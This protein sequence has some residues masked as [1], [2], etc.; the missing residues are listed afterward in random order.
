MKVKLHNK[1]EIFQGDTKITSYNTMLKSVYQAIADLKDFSSYIALGT[2][3]G[4]S[5]FDNENLEEY[6]SSYALTLEEKSCNIDSNEMFVKK[7]ITFGENEYSGLKFS[8]IGI[9]DTDDENPT[10]YNRILIKDEDG[11]VLSVE[12]REG[13]ALTIRITIYLSV[14]ND[15]KRFFT[16]G[17][18]PLL[19]QMMGESG[20]LDKSVY[21][22][23]GMYDDDNSKSIERVV[24][25]GSPVKCEIKT[26][27]S[28][29][30][31]F[32]F[33]IIAS[34]GT[35]ETL[36]VVFLYGGK[37]V[38]RMNVSEFG[39]TSEESYNF[40][41]D[42]DGYHALKKNF[43]GFTSLTDSET[44][45]EC[46]IDDFEVVK[47]ARGL[48]EV[49]ADIASFNNYKPTADSDFTLSADGKSFMIGVGEGNMI[50][51]VF[52]ASKNSIKALS[53]NALH[54]NAN[55]I[56]KYFNGELYVFGKVLHKFEYFD[57]INGGGVKSIDTE[58]LETHYNLS[59]LVDFDVVINKNGH[60]LLGMILT[61]TT[62]ANVG[63][64]GVFE[65]N[66]IGGWVCVESIETSIDGVGKVVGYAK[67]YDGEGRIIFF[68]NG[69]TTTESVFETEII[70][71][72]GS[73]I[74]ADTDVASSA[75]Y[76][77]ISS[78][79]C[80]KDFIIFSQ[81]NSGNNSMK[82]FDLKKKAWTSYQANSKFQN[83]YDISK[84]SKY[85]AE[86][87]YDNQYLRLLYRKYYDD[88]AEFE[89]SI[90]FT[91]NDV[92]KVIFTNDLIVFLMYSHEREDYY[93]EA[94]TYDE[95]YTVL[96]NESRANKT[97]SSVA[98]FVD[99]IGGGEFEGVEVKF[100]LRL[101]PPTV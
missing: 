5:V 62:G 24:P 95:R 53:Y 58:E 21:A 57:F 44:N 80:T 85:F 99:F 46:T 36:E 30:S 27:G 73:E 56:T 87:S 9:T 33:D 8:E 64:V 81:S 54:T 70:S 17:E 41:V 101:A 45:D 31:D 77:Y 29:E 88:F 18:N 90:D 61:L 72:S 42:E 6:V 20:S 91:K 59:T 94:Y 3:Q 32:S 15:S 35:G 25:V 1:V 55:R 65:R 60:L 7:S 75:F 47:I 40:T 83:I 37:A 63:I 71:E 26:N 39:T 43:L 93:F 67:E 49:V 68:A 78:I 51:N 14:D 69:N 23:R 48:G 12:K 84:N 13:E 98:R 66:E 96:K 74:L 82:V 10:I 100:S 76:E 19:L 92:K 22:M 28:A 16:L 50:N 38:A 34:L 11:N 97:F 2:G 89:K 4:E 86:R 52:L 79:D